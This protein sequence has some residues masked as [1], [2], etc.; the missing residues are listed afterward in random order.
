MFLTTPAPVLGDLRID[1]L[2]EMPFEPLVRPLL[3][4]SPQARIPRHIGGEDRGEAADGVMICPAVDLLNQVYLETGGGPNGAIGAVVQEVRI[5][6]RG[7]PLT[8]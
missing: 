8:Q 7:E 4:G 1:Q 5:G 2:P 3:I 6:R